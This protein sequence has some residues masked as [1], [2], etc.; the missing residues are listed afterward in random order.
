MKGQIQKTTTM[1]YLLL[2]SCVMC[3]ISCHGQGWLESATEKFANQDWAGAAKDFEKYLKK[4]DTDSA[5][6]YGL[7]MCQYHLEKYEKAISGLSEAGERNFDQN[8]VNINIAK[9][10]AKRGEEE[11]MYSALESAAEKGLATYARLTLDEEFES[12]RSTDRF[13]KIINKVERN[14][15][16]CLSDENARHFDFWLGEWDVYVGDQKVGENYITRAQGGC[17]IH[18]NYITTRNYAGQSINFYSP[19]DEKWH[20]HWVGSSGDV[21][22]YVEIDKKEGMLQFLSDFKNPFNDNLSLSRLTFTLNEDGTV[23]QL[24]ESSTD[25]GETWTSSFDGLYKKRE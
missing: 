14:A 7:G 20:Q 12:V 18:E 16:P 11:K 2:F 21:Y 13:Q 8:L 25:N 4:N 24:F 23:S 1:K 9:A 6:W 3:A 17:A 10:W 19:V 5:A 22:N 15:Y